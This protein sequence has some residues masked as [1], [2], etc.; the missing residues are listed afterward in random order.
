MAGINIRKVQGKVG[1]VFDSILFNGK[2]NVDVVKFFLD[3]G[4][5]ADNFGSY[6]AWHDPDTNEAEQLYVGDRVVVVKDKVYFFTDE[7]FMALFETYKAPEKESD[8]T[9]NA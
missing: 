2:N 7:V 6:I 4:E 9:T 8:D 3:R 5:H 1:E